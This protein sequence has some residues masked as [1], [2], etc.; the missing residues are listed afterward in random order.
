MSPAQGT[1]D[2]DIRLQANTGTLRAGT[3]SARVNII[4][5]GATNSPGT[6]RVTFRVRDAIPAT[7][8]P[9][10]ANLSFTSREGDTANPASQKLAI[11]MEGETKPDWTASVVSLNGGNWLSISP[12]A[13]KADGEITVAARLGDLPAGAYAAR[14]E[15]RSPGAA[16]P[17]VQVPVSFSVTR[18]KAI[19]AANGIVNAASLAAGPV[20]PGQ[21]ITIAGDRMGPRAG[22]SAK[23]NESTNRFA[24]SLGGTRVFFDGVPG[25]VLFAGMN[26]VNVMVPFEVAGKSKVKVSVESAGYEASDPV[27]VPVA[28]SAPGLFSA[29]GIRVAALNQDYSF[30]TPENPAAAGEV[31]QFFLTGQGLTTPRVDTGA[32]APAVAPFAA[33]DLGVRI[34]L[35]GQGA[36]VLFAGLAP[37]SI[38]L[39][40]VNVRIPLGITP[41]SN[42]L[43]GA[44]IGNAG[45]ASPLY[46]AVKAAPANDPQ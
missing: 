30:N 2:S 18:Q 7:V 22:V 1:G 8:R 9:A 12:A 46:L 16:N 34:L 3:Y 33:P 10:L 44:R 43:V 6:F 23:P 29:D 4:A 19:V 39:L 17:L 40:Q 5:P 32:L 25:I 20:A 42:V 31:V 36:E 15:I 27:E 14:I 24:T 13:G 11:R 35:D 41:S 28:E 37:G 21:L 26:Q 38:G 45:L